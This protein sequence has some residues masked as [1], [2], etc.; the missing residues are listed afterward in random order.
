MKLSEEMYRIKDLELK[1]RILV[2][3]ETI[4]SILA[5]KFGP[6]DADLANHLEE[7]IKNGVKSSSR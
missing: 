6:Y 2:Q 1:A 7:V 5:Y 3:L 4:S